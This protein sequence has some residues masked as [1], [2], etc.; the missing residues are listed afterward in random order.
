MTADERGLWAAVLAAPDDDLPRLVYA[1]WLEEN[2]R[3]PLA[4]FIRAQIRLAHAPPGHSDYADAV[5]AQS[6]AVAGVRA[7]SSLPVP[8]LPEGVRFAG[9]IRAVEEDG[10]GNYSRGFPGEVAIDGRRGPR[11][12]GHL[13]G[14]ILER[15]TVNWARFEDLPPATVE[16]LLEPT[17]GRLRGLSVGIPAGSDWDQDAAERVFAAAAV[18]ALNRLAVSRLNSPG[19]AALIAARFTRLTQFAVYEPLWQE[20]QALSRAEWLGGLT[21]ADLSA[22]GGLAGTMLP[23]LGRGLTSLAVRSDGSAGRDSELDLVAARLP[24]L[25]QLTLQGLGMNTQVG[26]ALARWPLPPLA[27]VRVKGNYSSADGFAAFVEAPW[28]AGVTELVVTGDLRGQTPTLARSPAAASVRLLYL[29]LRPTG[30]D[31]LAGLTAGAFPA[32]TTLSIGGPAVGDPA[33]VTR[34]AETWAGRLHTLIIKG[35]QVSPAAAQRLAANPAFASLRRLKL[36]GCKLGDAAA[37]ALVTGPHLQGVA[38]LDFGMNAVGERTAAALM[39]P[40]TLPELLLADLTGN[41]M[42]PDTRTR[43]RAARPGVWA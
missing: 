25:R 32:L 39:R 29:G 24:G 40:D 10:Y 17:A 11:P 20:W 31:D 12:G 41:R 13:L 18:T 4:A 14:R 15:T 9:H 26:R 37:A 42:H 5:E 6:L 35:W 38:E 36:R 21:H 23:A 27:A 19:V 33:E 8:E 7:A 30:T 43:L 22:N 2:G 16:A 1:D 34:F 3:G 28:L